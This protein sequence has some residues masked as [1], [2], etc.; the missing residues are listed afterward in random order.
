M[1]TKEPIVDLLPN[2]KKPQ[3]YNTDLLSIAYLVTDKADPKPNVCLKLIRGGAAAEAIAIQKAKEA[4]KK[5]K[6]AEILKKA[7]EEKK[8]SEV[9]V[10]NNSNSPEKVEDKK[11]PSTIKDTQKDKNQNKAKKSVAGKK[12]LAKN[13]NEQK[14]DKKNVKPE[15]KAEDKKNT[16]ATPKKMDK[17]IVGEDITTPSPVMLNMANLVGPN[18]VILT[19]TDAAGNTNSATTNFEVILTLDPSQLKIE[20][21]V[22]KQKPGTFTLTLSLPEKYD[23]KTLKK[24][25]ADG[26]P[27]YGIT[28]DEEIIPVKEDKNTK[29]AEISKKDNP[30]QNKKSSDSNKPD[31]NDNSTN[32]DNT[33]K[34]NKSV[35]AD[36]ENKPA[37]KKLVKAKIK[38]RLKKITADKVDNKFEIRG[39]FV[40][41]NA[42][43]QFVG[44]TSVKEVDA[45]KKR[46]IAKKNLE[47][48]ATN[49]KLNNKQG[50]SP[51]KK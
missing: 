18:S 14:E 19:A 31:K 29:S 12:N 17:M 38:F 25:T 40:H 4:E 16:A 30:T 5:R 24:V 39:K 44:Y 2:P 36:K 3:Y 27:G 51:K 35:K 49:N 33:A 37:V 43:C 11:K 50:K 42:I 32:K 10:K 22:I 13:K 46:E 34:K 9:K 48:K 28:F 21:E 26:A 6:I 7:D 20:P 1:D 47:A 15:K 8:A 45:P 23:L 41:E